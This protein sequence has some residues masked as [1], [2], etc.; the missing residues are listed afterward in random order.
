M[1]F[2]GCDERLHLPIV[3]LGMIPYECS[4]VFR[5]S[6][7]NLGVLYLTKKYQRAHFAAGG[8][9]LGD[10]VSTAMFGDERV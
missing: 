10:S 3:D 4:I 9:P 5:P 7:G 2:D 6:P 8:A 1:T